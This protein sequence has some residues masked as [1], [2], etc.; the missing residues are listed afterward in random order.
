MKS[1]VHATQPVSGRRRIPSKHHDCGVSA[2]ISHST[3]SLHNDTPNIQTKMECFYSPSVILFREV[4][5]LGARR[6]I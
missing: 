4:R 1:F 2:H 3:A 6:D 5:V